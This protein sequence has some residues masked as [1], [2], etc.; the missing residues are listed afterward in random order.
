MS[1]SKRYTIEIRAEYA[2]FRWLRV[3]IDLG[4]H[5]NPASC[6]HLKSGQL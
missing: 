5:P 1:T 3:E 6:G 2:P 4:G